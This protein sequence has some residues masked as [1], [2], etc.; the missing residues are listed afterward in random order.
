M[1][2][3][4]QR[5]YEDPRLADEPEEDNDTLAVG[6]FCRECCFF[7]EDNTF[8]DGHCSTCSDPESLHV[9]AKVVP[10]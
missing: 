3:D 1:S 5:C 2:E 9:E 4:A 7:E 8:I 6:A 10:L